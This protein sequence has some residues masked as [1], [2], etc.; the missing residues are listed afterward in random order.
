MITTTSLKPLLQ[1]F[2][3]R[4]RLGAGLS[5]A[6]VLLA[7]LSFSASS[8]NTS[9]S[10]TSGAV[11]SI[12]N[13]PNTDPTQE[14]MLYG[15]A[16][17]FSFECWAV[18]HFY[19]GSHF[20][21]L[22]EHSNGSSW[23][24]TSSAN[25]SAEQS[26]FLRGVACNNTTDC[27]A[28]GHYDSGSNVSA[29]Q[30]LIEHFD[31]NGRWTVVSSPNVSQ[32]QNNELNA[33]ACSSST[34]CWAVG[35]YGNTS[36]GIPPQQTLIEHWDGV[37]WS[38]T[39]SP[40]SG[41]LDSNVLHDVTC[42]AASECWAVGY[43]SSG[44]N[45]A[46]TLIE[47]YDGNAWT[48]VASANP[49][50]QRNGLRAVNCASAND[51]WAAGSQMGA[52]AEQTLL[53]HFD[54]TQWTLVSSPNT[55]PTQSNFLFGVICQ[56]EFTCWSAGYY[57][58]PGGNGYSLVNHYNSLDWHVVPSGNAAPNTAGQYTNFLTHATCMRSYCV[59]VGY[60]VNSNGVG[61]T[62]IEQHDSIGPYN[63]KFVSRKG[64]GAAG[65]FDID[66][67]SSYAVESRS[68]GASGDYQVVFTFYYP[69]ISVASAT[70]TEGVGTVSSSGINKDDP[71]QYIVNL[72]GV[73]NDQ[74]VAVTLYPV[75]DSEDYVGVV[76]H[77][78]GIL[79][80]DASRDLQVNSADIAQTKS[81]SG[82][83]VSSTN[84]RADV[85]GDGVI[86]SADIALVKSKSGTALP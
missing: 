60:Y 43:H 28:V 45:G 17:P 5:V 38:I 83:A 42:V 23:N 57:Q 44:V 4:C 22:I 62:L 65:T 16:C 41:V 29:F 63:N 84:F 61:Q 12:V 64:H 49:S 30:T 36:Q 9:A 69:L 39:P 40:N 8:A 1:R 46:Q 33:I 37:A 55:E 77:L 32:A 76:N 71:H 52:A 14:N 81:Q 85:T 68:G 3:L 11:W 79:V 73:P 74:A 19:N 24:I 72:T 54:G 20:Q 18:G 26:N 50:A 31:H 35:S 47:R 78:M 80:G 58:G 51:C 67:T 70:V 27:W 15:V 48:I 34:D 75:V 66:L 25:T 82:Q 7:G 6:G 53:E 13:S 2:D 56:A 59:A 86:N 10:G 21:T